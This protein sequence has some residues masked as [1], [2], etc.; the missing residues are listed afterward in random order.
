MFLSTNKTGF[1]WASVKLWREQRGWVGDFRRAGVSVSVFAFQRAHKIPALGALGAFALMQKARLQ[2]H[3]RESPGAW[4][5]RLWRTVSFLKARPE[6]KKESRGW[7]LKAVAKAGEGRYDPGPRTFECRGTWGGFWP[8]P[9]TSEFLKGT[10][11]S[12]QKG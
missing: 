12:Y 3:L 7:K 8:L 9:T 4:L 2:R 10:H 11:T 5:M 1:R 6:G